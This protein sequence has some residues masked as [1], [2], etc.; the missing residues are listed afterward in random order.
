MIMNV[1]S[2]KKYISYHSQKT[3]SGKKH[4]VNPL[5]LDILI[6]TKNLVFVKIPN[7]QDTYLNFLHP[8][9]V[10]IIYDFVVVL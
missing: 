8:P 1:N 9:L 4:P 10:H 6:Q 3:I 2:D 7:R 5:I